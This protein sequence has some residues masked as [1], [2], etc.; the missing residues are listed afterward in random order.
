M[1]EVQYCSFP[2]GKPVTAQCYLRFWLATTCNWFSFGRSP[3]CVD[4]GNILPA[5]AQSESRVEAFLLQAFSSAYLMLTFP[6]RISAHKRSKCHEGVYL[7]TSVS[8]FCFHTSQNLSQ[9]SLIAM[10]QGLFMHHLLGSI[11]PWF[12][13]HWTFNSFRPHS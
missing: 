5:E 10:W 2:T 8:P 1:W 9:L 13:V 3:F 4:E 12:T 11:F 7:R 6:S